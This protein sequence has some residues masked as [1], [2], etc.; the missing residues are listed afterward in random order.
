MSGQMGNID[1]TGAP[2]IYFHALPHV[3]EYDAYSGDYGLGFFGSSLEASSTLVLDS[4]LGPLC[5]LCDLIEPRS[6]LP[7]DVASYTFAPRDAY[8]QRV[9]L[10][11]LGLY[12]QADAGVIASVSLDLGGRSIRVVFASPS[13]TPAGVQSYDVLR[14]RAD[15][16]S[17]PEAKRPGTNFVLVEPAGVPHSRA[18]F[19]IPATSS[20]VTAVIG[21]DA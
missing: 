21:Y 6:E 5:Y 16:V 17:R 13:E 1:E 3:M 14:L 11:P 10:E 4:R 20:A 9:Y 19:E 8:R 18:A 2:A 15:K 7:A 12:L